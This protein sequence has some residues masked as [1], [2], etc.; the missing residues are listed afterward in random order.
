MIGK[1]SADQEQGQAPADW[2]PAGRSMGVKLG[3]CVLVLSALGTVAGLAGIGLVVAEVLAPRDSDLDAVYQKLTAVLLSFGIFGLIVGSLCFQ[4]GRDDEEKERQK[5]LQ[6][7]H[8]APTWRAST[9][10]APRAAPS[11][12]PPIQRP[13]TSD[14]REILK[15]FDVEA[16]P[17]ASAQV[18]CLYGD[19]EELDSL[20]DTAQSPS[21]DAAAQP[22]QTP[23]VSIQS[24]QSLAKR[25]GRH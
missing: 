9:R 7:P 3:I 21:S 2:V 15:A 6:E 24:K 19:S 14:K 12:L 1:P 11:S 20:A 8:P 17:G 10:V 13:S 4:I 25:T 5:V 23:V 22:E 18:S 16:K